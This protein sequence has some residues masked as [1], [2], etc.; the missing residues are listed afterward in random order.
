MPAQKQTNTVVT[1]QTVELRAIKSFEKLFIDL[2]KF[3]KKNNFKDPKKG[4][5]MTKVILAG[6]S[7]TDLTV[8]N[9]FGE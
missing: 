4:E 7:A 1:T 2:K 5:V 8:E 6:C 9:Y 3:A